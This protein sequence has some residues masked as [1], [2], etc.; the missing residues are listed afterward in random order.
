MADALEADQLD[1]A[2]EVAQHFA[3]RPRVPG[4]VYKL[5]DNS[6]G[7]DCIADPVCCDTEMSA[8]ATIATLNPDRVKEVIVPTGVRIDNYRLNPTVLWDHGFG[9]IPFPVGSSEKDGAL[10]LD[11][12]ETGID[13]TCYFTQKTLE[14]CQLYEL[15]KDK[16]VRAVSIHVQ[17]ITRKYETIEGLGKILLTLESDLIEW[18]WGCLGVNP[19]CV[20][21]TLAVGRLAGRPI[22]DHIK[23]MLTPYAPHRV[24]WSPGMALETPAVS[25]PAIEPVLTATAVAKPPEVTAEIVEPPALETTAKTLTAENAAK[26]NAMSYTAEALAAMSDDELKAVG[27]KS[28]ELDD[29]TQE[30]VKAEI[31]KRAAKPADQPAGEEK[32]GEVETEDEPDDTPLGA[33]VLTSIH[34]SIK[35]VIDVAETALKPV[36]NADVKEGAEALLESLRTIL[37]EV[38]GLF[39]K[40]YPDQTGLSSSGEEETPD[41]SES[42]VKSWLRASK[43]NELQFGGIGSQLAALASATNLKPAQRKS[44]GTAKSFFDKVLSTASAEAETA[45]QKRMTEIENT[46]AAINKRLDKAIPANRR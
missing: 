9:S 26:G 18:S 16:T 6:I 37:T 15:V 24:A 28:A 27:E 36:E 29:A 38:E 2:R 5:L 25:Q 34:E 22:T 19:A 30:L 40:S 8:R 44:L 11:I 3:D 21:K 17:P 46:L 23:Q 7:V 42:V 31:A 39:S 20:A 41:T 33:Q 1:I 43:R 45:E 32:P 10:S 35:G 13:A 4:S 12:R 14:A